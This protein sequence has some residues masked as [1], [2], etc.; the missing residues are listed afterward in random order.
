MLLSEKSENARGTLHHITSLFHFKTFN[1]TAK[2]YF[3]NIWDFITVKLLKSGDL[4]SLRVAHDPVL[5][6]F[7]FPQEE[8]SRLVVGQKSFSS[9]KI[10]IDEIKT[11][12]TATCQT[13]LRGNAEHEARVSH[14][15]IKYKLN[16]KTRVRKFT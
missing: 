7:M 6:I 10:Y 2:D 14:G 1:S 16:A 4:P 15:A 3:L 12:L 9:T 13:V 5:Y 11:G 8:P